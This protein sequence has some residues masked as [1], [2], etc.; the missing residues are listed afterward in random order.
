MPFR[1]TNTSSTFTTAPGGIFFIAENRG[2]NLTDSRIS[3]FSNIAI[4]LVLSKVVIIALEDSHVKPTDFCVE[5]KLKAA[6]MNNF[7]YWLQIDTTKVILN[8]F[9]K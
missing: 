8:V 7:E 5:T 2:L 1:K 3:S 6:G 4:L 9:N